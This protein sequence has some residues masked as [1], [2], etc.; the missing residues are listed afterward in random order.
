M[1]DSMNRRLRWSIVALTVW[2]MTSA[3]G[4]DADRPEPTGSGPSASGS[5]DVRPTLAVEKDLG[6]AAF[7]MA[8]VDAKLQVNAAGCFALGEN[9]LV[10]PDGST[11]LPDGSG[12]KISGGRTVKVGQTIRGGGEYGEFADESEV[13]ASMKH[14]FKNGR[15]WYVALTS[16]V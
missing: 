10:A 15:F 13:P 11:V 9:V 4:G 3:C 5:S 12:I 14:C 7:G 1:G 2:Y 6:H 16:V 8:S